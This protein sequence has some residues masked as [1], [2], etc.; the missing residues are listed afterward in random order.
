MVKFDPNDF[1]IIQGSTKIDFDPNKEEANRK[2]HKYSLTCAVDILESSA[3]FQQAFIT[4]ERIMEDSEVRH[5]HLAVYQGRIVH[6][7][8]TTREPETVRV[9]SIRDASDREREIFGQNPP[10][11]II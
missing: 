10:R 5:I 4:I 2:N 3:L 8:T 11:F 1:R 6:F 7:V 9:I